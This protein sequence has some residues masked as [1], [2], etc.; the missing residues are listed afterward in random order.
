MAV[1]VSLYS[2]DKFE[3]SQGQY[4]TKNQSTAVPV[5]LSKSLGKKQQDILREKYEGH[6]CLTL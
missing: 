3:F 6:A 2:Q 4:T 5:Y 1:I